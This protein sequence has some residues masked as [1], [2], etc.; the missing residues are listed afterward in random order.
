MLGMAALHLAP[1]MCCC[2]NQCTPT[3]NGMWKPLNVP[4]S[5]QTRGQTVHT[6]IVPKQCCTNEY[7]WFFTVMVFM[8]LFACFRHMLRTE[9][10]QA[11]FKGVTPSLVGSVP[12]R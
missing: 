7:S 1:E 9:G 11:L 4:Q 10:T 5:I 2:C 6:S 3:G 8:M 12:T